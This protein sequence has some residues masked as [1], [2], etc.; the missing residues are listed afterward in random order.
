ME[1]NKHKP[2]DIVTQLRQVEVLV[3]QGMALSMLFVRSAS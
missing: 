3:G 1:I 2:E